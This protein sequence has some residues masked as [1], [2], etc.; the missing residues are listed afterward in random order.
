[1]ARFQVIRNQACQK[2]IPVVL[3]IRRAWCYA[4]LAPAKDMELVLHGRSLGC[5]A[6][7][8]LLFAAL[9]ALTD[10]LG[11]TAFNVTAL[12]MPPDSAPSSA[13]SPVVVRR[14]RGCKHTI[15]MAIPTTTKRFFGHAHGWRLQH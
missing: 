3:A 10:G 5:P 6:L 9:R 4:A 7:A 11:V 8:A 13:G 1:M 12:R 14:A 15:P 2:C